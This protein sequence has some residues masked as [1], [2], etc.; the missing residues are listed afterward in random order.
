MGSS[1]SK[2]TFRAKLLEVW[3]RSRGA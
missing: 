3:A 1:L 2:T